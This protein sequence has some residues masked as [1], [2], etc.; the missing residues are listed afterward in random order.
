MVD[1]SGLRRRAL[2][3]E[4]CDLLTERIVS[5]G[6][7]PGSALPDEYELASEYGVSP[8]T[9]RKA[10]GALQADRL[11]RQ[12][13]GRG[14]FVVEAPPSQNVM[15]LNDI[16]GHAGKRIDNVCEVLDQTVGQPSENE[17]RELRLH[18]GETVLRT[19]R[20]RKQRGTPFLYEEACLAMSRFPAFR[21]GEAGDYDILALAWRHGFHL[22]RASEKVSLAKANPDVAVL[23]EVEPGTT[24]LRLERVIF[25]ASGDPIEW[26][27]G[28]CHLNDK[29]NFAEMH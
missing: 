20:L 5:G 28:F 10:L 25:S 16:R 1:S 24:L 7:Q 23:L 12:C 6:W 15:Y 14:A 29:G 27:V 26:R 3:L 19:R 8:G 18:P 4:L 9:V 17:Q 21:S 2:Y 22:P 11:V 13:P